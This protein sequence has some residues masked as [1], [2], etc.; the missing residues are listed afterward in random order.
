MPQEA[1]AG[2]GRF[3]ALRRQCEGVERQDM[4]FKVKRVGL[5]QAFNIRI[6]VRTMEK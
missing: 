4:R 6:L 5:L 2:V 3:S 1:Y